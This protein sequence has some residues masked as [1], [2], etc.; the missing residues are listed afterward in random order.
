MKYI[1]KICRCCGKPFTVGLANKRQI[2]CSK[3]C[4][5]KVG[6]EKKANNIIAK[7]T[8][9]KYTRLTVIE[10]Y[11]KDIG[12]SKVIYCKCLCECGNTKEVL[13]NS[14]RTKGT[15]SCG[16]LDKE[17]RAKRVNKDRSIV[18]HNRLY[19]NLIRGASKRGLEVTI[20]YE[21]YIEAIHKPC[22][23]CGKSNSNCIADKYTGENFYYNGIDRVDNNVG[24]IETNIV[25]CCEYCNRIKLDRPLEDF[26]QQIVNIYNHFIVSEGVTH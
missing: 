2:C 24:Y 23:Y 13:Y 21:Q 6:D 20:S 7:I 26:K 14:L 5:K 12:G 22:H 19:S 25:T 3:E 16:C 18:L 4:G 1:D 17:A 9:K 15:R 8:G 11:R 10:A